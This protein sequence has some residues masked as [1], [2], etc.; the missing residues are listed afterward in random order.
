M[1][2]QTSLAVS[3]L[4]AF[5][6]WAGRLQQSHGAHSADSSP[7][8]ALHRLSFITLF[9]VFALLVRHLSAISKEWIQIIMDLFDLN[10][11]Y[12]GGGEKSRTYVENS[13]QIQGKSHNYS[14]KK[15]NKQFEI[16]IP[17]SSH[18]K[19]WSFDARFPSSSCS[20]TWSPFPAPCPLP[21][22]SSL[23]LFRGQ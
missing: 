10:L 22:S 16:E 23:S 17:S 13:D 3:L 18:F 9:L 4:P 2:F 20:S 1:G 19:K 12:L 6:P 7:P 15:P 14:C 5:A 8:P 11:E 21:D